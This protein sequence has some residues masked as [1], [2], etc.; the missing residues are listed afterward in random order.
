MEARSF[1][2]T[3]LLLC[4][5]ALDILSMSLSHFLYKCCISQRFLLK[6]KATTKIGILKK[7]Y[8]LLHMILWVLGDDLGQVHSCVSGQSAGGS[9]TS[10][11]FTVEWR[12]LSQGNGAHWT[13]CLQSSHRLASLIDIAIIRLPGS[14]REVRGSTGLHMAPN[15]S[16]HQN[17]PQSQQ[18]PG[19]WE[20][21]ATSSWEAIQGHLRGKEKR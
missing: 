5:S 20:P 16:V 19:R 1:S 6:K 3:I 4:K 7:Q 2:F 18:R 17:L 15:T 11:D 21:R 12:A 8:L 10:N 9:L 14:K 13:S